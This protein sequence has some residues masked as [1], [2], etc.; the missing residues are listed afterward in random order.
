MGKTWHHRLPP[1]AALALI[2][3]VDLLLQHAAAD[4]WSLANSREGNVLTLILTD[5][6]PY[7]DWQTIAAAFAWRRSGQEGSIVRVA[8]CNPEDTENYSKKML[9][10]VQT[11]MAPLVSCTMCNSSLDTFVSDNQHDSKLWV[12]LAL[13][14]LTTLMQ[15]AMRSVLH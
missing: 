9:D 13:R 10:Y 14:Q 5:C 7:Q 11:H 8:N 4:K 3:L 15:L 6:S 1:A 12:N 2:C